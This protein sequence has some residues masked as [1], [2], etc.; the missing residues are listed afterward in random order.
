MMA[1]ANTEPLKALN[2]RRRRAC[3]VS[4]RIHLVVRVVNQR[5]MELLLA[6]PATAPNASGALVID[7][8]GDR[9]DGKATAHVASSGWRDRQVENSGL[10]SSV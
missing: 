4:L 5:R 8:T 1:L 6:G 3:K 7:E 10:V 9:K 2:A